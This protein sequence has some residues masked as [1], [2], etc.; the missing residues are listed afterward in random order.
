V[1]KETHPYR[2][3]TLFVDILGRVWLQGSGR[4]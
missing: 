1:H 2:D 4:K 3:V